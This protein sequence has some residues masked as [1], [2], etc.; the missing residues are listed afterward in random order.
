MLNPLLNVGR[1]LSSLP[2]DLM[3]PPIICIVDD[4]RGGG[5]GPST[6]FVRKY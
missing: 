4:F 5:G 1:I 3:Q 2:A 6:E